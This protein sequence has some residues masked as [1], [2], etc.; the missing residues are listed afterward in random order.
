VVRDTAADFE[1]GALPGLL[2]AQA[3]RSP[4]AVAVVSENQKLT[5]AELD[6]RSN[7][8]ARLLRAGPGDVVAV[9]IPRSAELAVALLAVLKTGAAYLPV[10]AGYPADRMRF[11]LADAEPACLV[12]VAETAERLP[13]TRTPVVVLDEPG[14]AAQL[15]GLPDDPVRAEVSPLDLAY[16]MYTSGST[17]PCF[18]RRRSASTCRCGSCSGRC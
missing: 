6:A 2:A 5:Y 7:R 4:G 8:M 10:E 11:M 3:R 17:R 13:A 15:A 18:T 1:V 9:A 16:V 12:T 14:I